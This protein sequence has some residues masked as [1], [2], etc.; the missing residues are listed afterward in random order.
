MTPESLSRTLRSLETDGVKVDGAQI[1]ITD[2]TRL[3][4]IAKM[5]ELM[6]LS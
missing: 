3:H 5:E 2:H 6:D 1:T 4:S